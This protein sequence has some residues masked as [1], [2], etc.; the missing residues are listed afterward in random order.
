MKYTLL[1][2]L[3]VVSLNCF[4]S[5]ENKYDVK[6]YQFRDSCDKYQ[7]SF[8]S[9]KGYMDMSDAIIK[10]MQFYDSMLTYKDSS[11]NFKK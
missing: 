7:R 1:A 10:G 8:D 11:D 6:F 5:C 2:I 9:A 3:I 4:W